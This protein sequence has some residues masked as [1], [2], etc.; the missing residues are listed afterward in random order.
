MA[1]SD[2]IKSDDLIESGAFDPSIEGAKL[3]LE[4][5]NNLEKGIKSLASE[6]TKYFGTSIKSL[7]QL[8]KRVDALERVEKLDKASISL[9]KQKA[10]VE[11]KL[12]EL[13]KARIESQTRVNVAKSQYRK[14]IKDSIKLDQSEATSINA[15]RVKLRQLQQQWDSLSE[16]QRNNKNIGGAILK[17]IQSLDSK[18]KQL[19]ETTGRH[20]RSVGNYAKSFGELNGILK[21]VE[22]ATGVNLGLLKDAISSTKAASIAQKAYNFVVGASTG[23]MKA[24]KL[25]LAATGIGAVIALLGTLATSFIK[26]GNETDKYR[27]KLRKLREEKYK[28]NEATNETIR[29]EDDLALRMAIANGK[30]TEEQAERIKAA[31]ENVQ[32]MAAVNKKF[33][34]MIERRSEQQLNER[35]GRFI[36][37]ENRFATVREDIELRRQE[38]LAQLE[39]EFQNKIDTIQFEFNEKRKDKAK[40]DAEKDKKERERIFLERE[41]Q[42][43]EHIQRI[44][45]ER[46]AA[47]QQRFKDEEDAENDTKDKK[48]KQDEQDL[49][50]FQSFIDGLQKRAEEGDKSALRMLETFANQS[51]KRGEIASDALEAAN[52]KILENDK[53]LKEELLRREQEFQDEI[54]NIYFAA[55]KKKLTNSAADQERLKRLNQLQAIS[56]IGLAYYQAFQQYTK[57]PKTTK[58]AALLAAK[59]VFTAKTLAKLVAAG[60]G[61]YEGTEEVGDQHAAMKLSRSK[62]NLL[63]P[64][65]KG[66][67]VIGF[68]DSKRIAGMTNEQLVS[69]GEMFKMGLLAPISDQHRSEQL[70]S[71]LLG[72][73]RKDVQSLNKTL[74]DKQEITVHR[75]VMGELVIERK[76]S[77]IHKIITQKND[78][79]IT[80]QPPF[81]KK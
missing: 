57:D 55:Q 65:H 48:E 18:V 19:E 77:G 66:E 9:G 71:A 73:L 47:Y 70:N 26:T 54:L 62:D 72:M 28:L 51:G 7:E 15:L 68:E 40:K 50:D 39:R 23:A 53:K 49:K 42:N 14:E 74:R 80:R 41:K 52:A 4:Q 76:K 43:N 37:E 44:L 8:E 60:T 45:E 38:E 16:S 6:T 21:L 22:K 56:E 64:L 13:D 34:A 20:G 12:T 59:D 69:L 32:K 75:N 31:N 78:P 33:N 46:E 63:V 81:G 29:A 25:A 10:D 1:E 2:P 24:F 27:E 35:S 30:I 3:L 11:K 5:V 17:D 61:L 36:A 67:R 79:I 58:Q